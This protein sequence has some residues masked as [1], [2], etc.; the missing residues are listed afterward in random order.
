MK[1]RRLDWKMAGLAASVVLS[2]GVVAEEISPGRIIAGLFTA[3]GGRNTYGV[4]SGGDSIIGDIYTHDWVRYTGVDLTGA[5]KARI[6]AAVPMQKDVSALIYI[7]VED[8][9]DIRGGKLIGRFD[10]GEKLD[11]NWGDLN[12]RE[13]ELIEKVEGVHKVYILFSTPEDTSGLGTVAW[14]EFGN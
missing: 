6:M 2:F 10:F 5:T 11:K 1:T 14:I 12:M 3:T 7:N 8:E 4:H 9:R 13:V